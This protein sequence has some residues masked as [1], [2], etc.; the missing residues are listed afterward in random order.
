MYVE[1][2]KETDHVYRV[3]QGALDRARSN[4]EYRQYRENEERWFSDLSSV[5]PRRKREFDAIALSLDRA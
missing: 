3:R 1:S 2:N 5:C 4:R